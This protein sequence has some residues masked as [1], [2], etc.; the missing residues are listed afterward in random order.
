M[1]R[2]LAC[3]WLVAP[4]LMLGAGAAH[5]AASASGGFCDEA[6]ATDPATL[7]RELRFAAHVQD[8]LAASDADVALVARAGLNLGLVGQTWSH[9]ALAQRDAALGPWAVRQLYY[10]CDAK[11]SRLFDQGLAGFVAG[12]RAG[13]T[14][15]LSVVLLPGPAGRALGEA[16]RD[17]ARAL[18]V[19]G[20]DYSANA[21]AFSTRYENCNQWLAEL[22]AV[23]WGGAP[24]RAAAQAWLAASG[25]KPVPVHAGL[26]MFAGWFSPWLHD[27]D[28]PRADLAAGVYRVSLPPALEDF[29]LGRVPG[30]RRLEFCDGPDCGAAAPR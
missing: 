18:G 26:L 14:L 15:R 24:D 1:S 10:A 5:A 13:A 16:A 21:Y 22:M 9:A 27:A 6:R 3:A 28:H 20:P 19:L 4:L 17:D 29:A 30:A 8:V 2:R 12:T 25:Y 7:D 11:R 23:A